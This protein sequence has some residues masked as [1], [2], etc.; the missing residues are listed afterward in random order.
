MARIGHQARQP[1]H[2][3]RLNQVL[4][5]IIKKSWSRVMTSSLNTWHV[6]WKCLAATKFVRRNYLKN[7]SKRLRNSLRITSGML[8][9]RVVRIQRQLVAKHSHSS[10]VPWRHVLRTD[11]MK[12][13]KGGADSWKC[14]SKT[15]DVFKASMSNILISWNVKKKWLKSSTLRS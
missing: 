1:L 7:N 12:C 8:K 14:Y 9:T 6:S 11:W 4:A 2:K 3:V 10:W 5:T 15:K 13:L